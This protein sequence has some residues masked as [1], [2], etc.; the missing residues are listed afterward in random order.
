MNRTSG[1]EAEL[2][3]QSR[4]RLAIDGQVAR[5]ELNRPE[6]GN[7]IDLGLARELKQALHEC[8]RH[9]GLCAIVI[10]GA[11]RLFCAGGDLKAIHA[12]GSNGP[13]YVRELLD[14]LHECISTIARIPTP[15]IAAVN[16]TAAGAG[17][18]LACACDLL[19]ATR[20][21]KFIMAYTRIGLTPD[22]SSTWYLPRLLGLHRAMALTLLNDEIDAETLRDWGVIFD[23]V[24]PDRL[25]ECVTALT[26]RLVSGT[27][28]ASGAA[29]RLLR[30][31][32][33]R[34]LEIQ[35]NAEADTL[36]LALS[37]GEARAGLESFL[38]RERD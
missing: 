19:V 33:G 16:G 27:H 24:E 13:A 4:V 20:T 6:S 36:C 18:A 1:S 8:E 30:E 5:I 3:G 9:S 22:G 14:H 2:A 26:A 10:T 17:F 38:N 12:Q 7:A 35:M 21:A 25:A 15:V 34:S 28:A 32:S 37:G 29:K 11:G 23:V 31:S